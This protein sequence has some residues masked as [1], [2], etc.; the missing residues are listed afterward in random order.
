VGC[1]ANVD[2]APCRRSPFGLRVAPEEFKVDDGVRRGQ[3]D[4][5]F[6]D[7]R[8]GPGPDAVVDVFED[9]VGRDRVVPGFLFRA[10]D[11]IRGC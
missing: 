7:G 8:P 11:L 1:V 5:G 9:F 6:E 10:G 2:Y 4:E 3:L